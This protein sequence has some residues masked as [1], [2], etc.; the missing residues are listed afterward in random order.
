MN[1]RLIKIF[2]TLLITCLIACGNGDEAGSVSGRP[3]MVSF[4]AGISTRVL[5]G[6]WESGDNIGI[7][8]LEAGSA[9]ITGEVLNRCYKV[10]VPGAVTVFLPENSAETI[11]YP[12]DDSKVDFIAYYPYREGVKS[13]QAF[14]VTVAGQYDRNEI[15]LLVARTVSGISKDTPDVS[16]YFQHCWTSLEFKLN[17]GDAGSVEKLLGARIKIKGIQ[18]TGNYNLFTGELSVNQV[19]EDIS[20]L[21]T[22]AG[23][24]G[25]AIVFPR[26]AGEEVR[27]EVS[28]TSGT[29]Y[30]AFL[31]AGSEWKPGTRYTY[32]ITLRKVPVPVDIAVTVTDWVESDHLGD[33][34]LEL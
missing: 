29:V 13:L 17:P 9:T 32:S 18:T 5:N 26:K 28:L 12:A 14:P 19:G 16:L 1:N 20:A 30:T 6:G 7:T 2:C 34:N 24:E 4:A 15:D 23:T 10:S 33:G 31:N 21:M 11:Y 8:M 3:V 22:S 25:T 27:F